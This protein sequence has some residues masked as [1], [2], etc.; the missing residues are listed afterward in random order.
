MG[1]EPD[2]PDRGNPVN[3]IRAG[4][5]S[6]QLLTFGSLNSTIFQ[7]SGLYVKAHF[8]DRGAL[9]LGASFAVDDYSGSIR[10]QFA[11]V[12]SDFSVVTLA[13]E[14]LEFLD[15]SGSVTTFVG[16][17]PYWER[18]SGSGKSSTNPGPGYA[19]IFRSE[20]KSWE[21]GGSASFGFE[22]FLKQ[23]LSVIGR[24]G[25]SLGIGKFHGSDLS[26]R[27]SPSG[28][29]IFRMNFDEDTATAS[30][31]AAALGLSAYF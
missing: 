1:S 2:R 26:Q 21:L 13:A 4:A 16:V 11:S 10:S 25:A 28:V 30:S 29:E 24:M 9:R 22:W 15:A 23:K 12:R 31:T 20:S 8:S 7:T 3:S 19:S 27:T 18:G 17:G 14:V 6:I 5:V